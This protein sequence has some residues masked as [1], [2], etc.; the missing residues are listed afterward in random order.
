MDDKYKNFP[1]LIKTM[2]DIIEKQVSEAERENEI[3][4]RRYFNQEKEYVNTGH[5]NFTIDI[6]RKHPASDQPSELNIL[7]F[8]ENEQKRIDFYKRRDLIYEM[9]EDDA[10]ILE[11]CLKHLEIIQ[12]SLSDKLPKII[13]Y[14]IF[15]STTMFVEQELADALI[16]KWKQNKE[17]MFSDE[18][19]TEQKKNLETNIKNSEDALEIVNGM[20]EIIENFQNQGKAS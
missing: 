19:Q 9:W 7:D 8:K 2:E 18:S 15:Y 5:K 12:D 4:I 14:E 10:I 11:G 13:H 1:K 20:Q 17:T 6:E 3:Q 16:D